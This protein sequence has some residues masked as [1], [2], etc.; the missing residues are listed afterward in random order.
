MRTPDL[1]TSDGRRPRRKRR[2]MMRVTH[3]DERNV[4]YACDK[5]GYWTGYK[6]HNK[7]YAQV[8][9]GEHCPHCNRD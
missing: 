6:L 5:C 7:T 4:A 1:F 8:C 9:R 3:A 2:V